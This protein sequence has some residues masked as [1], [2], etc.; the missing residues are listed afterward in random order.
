MKKDV[1]IIGSGPAGLTAAIY[2]ARAR[3]DTVL[4]AGV[5]FGGQL[6]TT[7]LVE[8]FPGFKE[9]IMGPELMMNM[10]D[11]AKNQGAEVVYKYANK[12]DFSGE[13]KKVWSDSGEEYEAKAVIIAAGSSPRRLN[14]PGEKE[15]W[16]KGVSTCATCDGA[17]YRDKVVAVVGG[18]DSAMEES[19]F[20]TRFAKKVYVIHRRDQL[21]ASAAMQERAKSN[22]KIQFIWNTEVLEVIGEGVVKSLK[23][24]DIVEDKESTLQVDGMFLA[25]GHL[26]NSDFLKGHVE[27]DEKGYV[28]VKEGSKCETSV[29]GVFVSGDIHDAHYEQAITAAGMGCMAA[30]DA[31]KWLASKS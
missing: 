23:L 26:P 4:I 15:Y 10:V 28:K 2:S 31:E 13:L 12:V 7:S 17:F 30:M 5:E 16:G 3:L 25:I 1:V 29:E 6:M 27:L 22:E 18:G 9:G 20:L 24:K 19:T 21:R 11:Q 8:N 14:I